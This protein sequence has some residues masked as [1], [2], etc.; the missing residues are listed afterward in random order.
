MLV[1]RSPGL[2]CVTAPASVNAALR[3]I[4]N[5]KPDVLLVDARLLSLH[6]ADLIAKFKAG[7]PGT[8]ILILTTF[9]QGELLFDAVRAGA[10]G[11][12]PKTTPAAELVRAVQ[13]AHAG[14]SP[15]SM[16]MARRLVAHFQGRQTTGK[17]GGA[18]THQE[19]R[20]LDALARGV[21]YRTV[22]DESGLGVS[23]VLSHLRGVC[24]KL[25]SPA[26][27]T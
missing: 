12:M 23:T 4:P 5:L 13:W 9:E 7:S 8:R 11:D 25:G 3:I 20:I 17:S 6:G 19:K 22:A 2:A 24:A 26:Y 18:L 16:P 1:N 21:S 14:G 10:S 27:V 15:I